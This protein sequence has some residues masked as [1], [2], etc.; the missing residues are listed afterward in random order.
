MGRISS[1]ADITGSFVRHTPGQYSTVMLARRDWY[2]QFIPHPGMAAR[3]AMTGMPLGS[4]IV[5]SMGGI[6]L[7]AQPLSSAFDTPDTH[8]MTQSKLRGT[9]RSLGA[10]SFVLTNAVATDDTII[11]HVKIEDSRTKW[12]STPN[13]S[14]FIASPPEGVDHFFEVTDVDPEDIYDKSARRHIGAA[15]VSRYLNLDN[16]ESDTLRQVAFD[17]RV[18]LPRTAEQQR[19]HYQAFE[20]AVLGAPRRLRQTTSE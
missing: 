3:M 7:E 2:D 17:T 8:F 13:G 1:E 6:G 10:Y 5:G 12:V 16:L 18:R 19:E 9:E 20:R 4:V 14:F 11:A 15:G